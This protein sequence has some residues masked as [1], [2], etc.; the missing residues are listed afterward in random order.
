MTRPRAEVVRWPEDLGARYAVVEQ[1]MHVLHGGGLVVYPTDTVYGL[2]ADAAFPDAVRRIFEVKR[3]PDEKAIIWLV[4]SLDA[5]RS[6]CI[7]DDRAKRLGE[8]FWP[9]ALTLVLPRRDPPP[10]ALPTLG[11]RV[12]AHP[13][14]LAILQAMDRP[15]ATTSA[16]RSTE[17]SARTAEEAAATIGPEVDLIIDAGAAPGGIESSVLDLSVHP[18]RL[19]RAGA[20]GASALE[21][22]LSE[23]I[24]APGE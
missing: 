4:H 1:A 20:I 5:A 7:V 9:G 8:E 24:L 23:H 18:A 6:A 22:A 21:A 16:N 19:L 12:P 14:A 11:V 2:G 17:P 15:V 3:R 13:A 10:G